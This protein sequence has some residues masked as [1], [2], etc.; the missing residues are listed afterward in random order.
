MRKFPRLALGWALVLVLTLTAAVTG[1]AESEL[2]FTL[3]NKTG[4]AIKEVY[5]APSTQEAWEETDKNVLPRSLKDEES[6]D[7]TFHPKATAPKWD[8][9]IV[10]ADGGEAVEWLGFDL[11][12]ISKIT[13]LYDE[14]TEKTSAETE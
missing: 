1:F 12:A 3:V 10:W 13:L 11:T 8:L 7:I 9:K 5:I 4:Y 6:V 14:K 2:D